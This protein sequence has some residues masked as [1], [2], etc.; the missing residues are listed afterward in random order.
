[1]QDRSFRVCIEGRSQLNLDFTPSHLHDHHRY[2]NDQKVCEMMVPATEPVIQH[3]RRNLA[4]QNNIGAGLFLSSLAWPPKITYSK[5]D[6]RPLALTGNQFRPNVYHIPTEDNDDSDEGESAIDALLAV[7]TH[8]EANPNA[9]DQSDIDAA[10]QS[11]VQTPHIVTE[12][13]FK[14]AVRNRPYRE[15]QGSKRARHGTAT[16]AKE[17]AQLAKTNASVKKT[18]KGRISAPARKLPANELFLVNSPPDYDFPA[19]PASSCHG[20]QLQDP[21]H[22]FT[23]SPRKRS[24]SPISS[25]DEGVASMV[26][27]AP[28][29]AIRKRLQ[30][31]KARFKSLRGLQSSKVGRRSLGAR[32]DDEPTGRDGFDDSELIIPPRIQGRRRAKHETALV[33]GFDSLQLT[34]GPLP[35]VDFES[36]AAELKIEPPVYDDGASQVDRPRNE[37][38]VVT[39][40]TRPR[41]SSRRR[42]SFGDRVRE[43]LITAQLSSISAP[44]RLP[45]E[46]EESDNEIDEEIDVGDG[47]HA[48]LPED[49]LREN[50]DEVTETDEAKVHERMSD[51]VFLDFRRQT[52]TGQLP[53]VSSSSKRRALI[54]VNEAIADVPEPVR[55][56]RA[57]DFVKHVESA[58]VTSSHSHRPRSILKNSILPSTALDSSTRPE[59]TAANTRRNSLVNTLESRYFTDAASALQDPDPARH[60]IIPRRTSNFTYEDQNVDVLD[61]DGL[62]PETSPE[63]PNYVNTSDLIVLRRSSAAVWTSSSAP[64]ASMDLKALTRSV[65]REHGTLS[66]SVRRRISQ[67]FQSPT[68]LR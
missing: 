42:V 66:Q 21:I 54:E 63:T 12:T 28:L 52:I 5:K 64:R 67:P 15:A 35:D 58:H 24:V 25:D 13:G 19:E 41:H 39:P 8:D 11:R 4:A 33:R 47:E 23:S 37:D 29:S 56:R 36:S 18:R 65:S 43:D 27:K 61:T 32:H 2:L 20:V 55:A 60:K 9:S 53:K 50:D 46:S 45:S 59:E 62:V 51:G 10:S 22:D 40:R 44:E 7:S 1:M 14:A 30:T 3:G 38:G 16:K 6:A 49:E 48:D 31:P 57:Y 68:K 34:S 17:P 26:S